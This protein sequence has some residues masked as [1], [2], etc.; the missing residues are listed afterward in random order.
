MKNETKTERNLL[1]V[2]YWSIS[3][4]KYFSRM[5]SANVK[6]PNPGKFYLFYFPAWNEA[7]LMNAFKMMGYI[8]LYI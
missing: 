2:F 1:M 8:Y 7:E 4:I 6:Y 3:K 5:N